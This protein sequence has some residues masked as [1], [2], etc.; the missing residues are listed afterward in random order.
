M[1]HNIT[2]TNTYGK[3]TANSHFQDCNDKV[4][5]VIINN[6]YVKILQK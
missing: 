3:G 1:G 6:T 5:F 2:Q 4:I